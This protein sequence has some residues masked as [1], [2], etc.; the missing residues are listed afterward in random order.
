MTAK[1]SCFCLS[2]WWQQGTLHSQPLQSLWFSATPIENYWILE[3]EDQTCFSLYLGQL[4]INPVLGLSSMSS[5]LCS[6]AQVNW[7]FSSLKLD[8]SDLRGMFV[9]CVQVA[10]KS[11]AFLMSRTI[12]QKES[13][14]LPSPERMSEIALGFTE[15]YVSAEAE[16]TASRCAAAGAQEHKR[17]SAF[18]T[19]TAPVLRS[20]RGCER[21]AAVSQSVH[22]PHSGVMCWGNSC[23]GHITD[24]KDGSWLSFP[25]MGKMERKH[26]ASQ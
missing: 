14:A 5:N 3:K 7:R 4:F 24:G 26:S 22:L 20:G 9:C 17:I 18:T 11:T 25:L 23:H 2:G 8:C 21:R 12:S 6:S 10:A 1:A 13:S 15:F 16:D 19:G